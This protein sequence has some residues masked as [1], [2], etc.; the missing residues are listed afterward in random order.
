MYNFHKTDGY[1]L[2]KTGKGQAAGKN[3][4]QEVIDGTR[5]TIHNS[6]SHNP[7]LIIEEEEEA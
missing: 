3:T 7:Y 2:R 5:K 6:G 4:Q 1:N